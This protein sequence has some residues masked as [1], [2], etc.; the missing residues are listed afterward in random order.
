V[1][2]SASTKQLSAALSETT[3]RAFAAGLH[4]GFLIVLGVCIVMLLLALLLKDVPLRER[5]SASPEAEISLEMER[6]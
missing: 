2:I 4:M 3:R 1:V 5:S 6:L